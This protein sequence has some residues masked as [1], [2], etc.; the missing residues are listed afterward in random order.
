[1]T[2]RTPV[3]HSLAAHLLLALILAAS[4]ATA[5]PRLQD[6]RGPYS[7]EVW[8][9]GRPARTFSH[10][11]ESYVLGERGRR[12]TL[13]VQNHSGR[14]VEIV[15]TVDGRDVLDGRPGS[16]GK[17][18]YLLPAWGS[19][20]IEG[21]RLSQQE[22]AAFRFSSVGESYAARTGDARQVGVIGVAFFPEAPL[23][24]PVY[25]PYAARDDHWGQNVPDDGEYAPS[26]RRRM[27]APQPP[28]ASAPSGRAEGDGAPSSARSSESAA[29]ARGR[30]A[31][32]YERPGLGTAFGERHY[33]PVTNVPFE[34]ANSSHPSYLLG[35]RYNDARGLMAMGIDLRPWR[36]HYDEAQ[37][38]RYATPFPAQPDYAAPPPGWDE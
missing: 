12:Y 23:P 11:G 34:R 37:R 6:R 5:A 35:L 20:T 19:V 24:P 3:R 27:S 18:G 17:R 26:E 21:W 30:L 1:M 28:A 13:R 32:S 38:R 4:C 22:I 7:V 15:A 31:P 8:I 16:F 14:R 9:D 36:R 2:H 33:A 25:E 29:A 10:R